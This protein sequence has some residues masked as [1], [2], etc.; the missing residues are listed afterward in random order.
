[1]QCSGTLGQSLFQLFLSIFWLPLARWEQAGTCWDNSVVV[2]LPQTFAPVSSVRW[3]LRCGYGG[4]RE[5]GSLVTKACP[6][7]QQISQHAGDTAVLYSK[8]GVL[9]FH[10]SQIFPGIYFVFCPG[11][12]WNITCELNQMLTVLS[13]VDVL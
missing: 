11:R 1:M 5:T 8:G 2:K 13:A 12:S 6:P 10:S 7:Q 9:G 3:D 4:W